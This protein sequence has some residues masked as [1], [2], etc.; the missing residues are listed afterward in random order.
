MQEEFK[1]EVWVESEPIKPAR[2]K[3]VCKTFADEAGDLTTEAVDSI[4]GESVQD[5]YTLTTSGRLIMWGHLG[6]RLQYAGYG[7]QGLQLNSDGEIL[8]YR[9]SDA[10]AG[11]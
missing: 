7:A 6:E 1:R 10:S 5:L 8:C 9:S 2:K 3:W 4:T 11:K